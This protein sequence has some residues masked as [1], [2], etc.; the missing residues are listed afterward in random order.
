MIEENEKNA[1]PVEGC[2][3][4]AGCGTGSEYE[5]FDPIITL[6]DEEGNDV[7]FE[8]ID[9]VVLDDSKQY[10]IVTEAG[11]DDSDKETEVTILEIK[12]EDGDE[13]YDTV[14]DKEIAEKVFNKFKEQQANLSNDVEDDDEENED[15]E[16]DDDD[17]ED[18]DDQNQ[19][20]E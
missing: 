19:K 4:C 20:D 2:S 16:D 13:V 18:S 10:V 1:C 11:Q 3:A 12:D 7:Q 9:V 5:D 15:D 14:T 8:I 17:E 6:T